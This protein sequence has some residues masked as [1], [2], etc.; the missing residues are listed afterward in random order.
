MSHALVLILPFILCLAAI[1][2]VRTY[3]IPNRLSVILII[4]FIPVALVAGLPAS[5]VGSH[6]AVGLA[7]LIAGFALFSFGVFGGGDA[8]LLAAASV[9]FGSAMVLPFILAVA[10]VGGLLATVLVLVRAVP[11][12]ATLARYGW[13]EKLYDRKSGI[14]YG[15]AIAAG[16]LVV[17]P[18]VSWV[19]GLAAL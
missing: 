14:P 17:F 1:W 4:S 3:T 10:M 16:G 8:K 11:M 19:A 13:A 7:V 6:F 5:V 9:W 2:D 12:P 18:K 15:V